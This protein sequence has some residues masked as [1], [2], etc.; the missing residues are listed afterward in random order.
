MGWLKEEFPLEE[1]VEEEK[2][3]F[4]KSPNKENGMD[5]TGVVEGWGIWLHM[6]EKLEPT[7][8]PNGWE[9]P[10]SE[11]DKGGIWPPLKGNAFSGEMVPPRDPCRG[12]LEIL[13]PKPIVCKV[14]WVRVEVIL[15]TDIP[16]ENG[17]TNIFCVTIEWKMVVV[18][19]GTI[20]LTEV[21]VL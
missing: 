11:G 20:P 18:M 17:P 10:L 5:P 6:L 8:G 2:E 3:L 15:N 19:I 14:Y 7:V 21:V 9:A 12:V 4:P 13:V 16:Y 1:N